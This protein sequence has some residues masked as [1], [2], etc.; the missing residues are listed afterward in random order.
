MRLLS[1]LNLPG[2]EN[3]DATVT[4][5]EIFHKWVAIHDVSSTTEHIFQRFPLKKY[6]LFYRRRAFNVA[7]DH[8]H[9]ICGKLEA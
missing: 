1:T 3:L 7:N 6:V 2:F 9:R 4:F 5:L 8:V